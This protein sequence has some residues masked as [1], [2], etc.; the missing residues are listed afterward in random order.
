MTN[1]CKLHF[2]ITV[3][4]HDELADDLGKDLAVFLL[5][6]WTNG[7]DIIDVEYESHDVIS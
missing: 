1:I 4:V 5:E 2:T 7:E 6:S 3:H